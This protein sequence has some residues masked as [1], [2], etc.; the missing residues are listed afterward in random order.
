MQVMIT[1][2]TNIWRDC[3]VLF[4]LFQEDNKPDLGWRLRL[5]RS[6]PIRVSFKKLNALEIGWSVKIPVNDND[7]EYAHVLL[8]SALADGRYLGGPVSYMNWCAHMYQS[9]DIKP[10]VSTHGL[11]FSLVMLSTTN[12]FLEPG[13]EVLWDYGSGNREMH[14]VEWFRPE[15]RKFLFV[16]HPIRTCCC[17]Y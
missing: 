7:A 6:L 2:I 11:T 14:Y 16:L 1:R 3:S 10:T 17:I 4:E 12:A 13:Q 8:R 15:V 5:K 9:V